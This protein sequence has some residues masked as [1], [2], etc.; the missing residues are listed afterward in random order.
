MKQ[1]YRLGDL[2]TSRG[3]ITQGQLDE[4]LIYQQQHQ[5][6][7]GKALVALGYIK[8][9]K[10]HRTL[11][12]QH[13]LRRLAAVTTLVMAP[14]SFCHGSN[15]IELLPEYSYTQVAQSPCPF[16]ASEGAYGF[17]TSTVELDVVQAATAALWYVSQGGINDGELTDVPVQLNLSS[18]GI[19][20]GVSLSLSVRF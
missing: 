6:T 2:L 5:L 8:R 9:S 18:D 12:K 13:W 1:N 17:D 15:E 16:D 10:V 19:E 20:K 14:L 11:I 3:V 4:A 7:L